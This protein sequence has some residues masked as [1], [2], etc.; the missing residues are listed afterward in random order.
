MYF[1]E[2]ALKKIAASYAT[3]DSRYR[4]LLFAYVCR[5]FA[6][7]K[8]KEYATQGFPRRLKILVRCVHQIFQLLPPESVDVPDSTIIADATIN[9]QA[10]LFNV[11]G[12]IDNLAWVWVYEKSLKR[13]DG[14]PLPNAWVGL[15]PEN[16]FLRSSFSKEFQEHLANLNPWFTHLANF[17]HALAHRILL[18]IPP[19][20][21]EK[22]KQA[23]YLDLEAQMTEAIKRWDFEEH[24]RLS[25]EQ[26]KL[27]TFRPWMQHSFAENARAVVFHPQLIADFNTIDELGWKL[28]GELNRCEAKSAR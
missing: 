17:R 3:I 18:Y 27:A 25:A 22:S 19:Y 10:F 6:N 5:T 12:A 1:S 14:T 28:L 2:D 26:M 24:E 23:A 13:S 7:D 21:V 20:I 8:A 15:G 16:R 4:K 11:F 9:I